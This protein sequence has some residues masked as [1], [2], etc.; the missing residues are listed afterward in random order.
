MDSAPISVQTP[1]P[2]RNAKEIIAAFRRAEETGEPL[3]SSLLDLRGVSFLAQSLSGLDL[4]GCDFTGAEMSRC[5]LRNSICAQAIFDKTTMFQARLDGAEFLAASFKEANL[6]ECSAKN[7]GFGQCQLSHARFNMA[8]LTNATF[9]SAKAD[10]ADFRSCKM[11]HA[12]FLEA[13]LTEADFSQSDMTEVD[14]RDTNVTGATFSRTTLRNARLRGVKNYQ[15]AFWIDADIREIDF[16]GAYMVRRHVVDENFLHE[17]RN[18]SRMHEI[19]YWVWWLTS[20]CGRSLLRWGAFC[21]AIIFIYGVI[22]LALGSQIAYPKGL[23]QGY[24]PWYVSTMLACCVSVDILPKTALAQI[25]LSSEVILG[26]VGF[27]GLLTIIAAHFGTRG[28]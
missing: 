9:V 3:D 16:A 11:D 5:D 24:A 1:P 13:D 28:E 22:Y 15:T 19:I 2:A 10:H 17:F 25:I 4:S 20:D 7:A 26:Y 21:A 14:L 12:R 6:T 8:N 27:A 23:A 18:Q